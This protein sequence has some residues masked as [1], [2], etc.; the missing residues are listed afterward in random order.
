M[1]NNNLVKKHIINNIKKSELFDYPFAHKFIE[2]IF[3]IE[4]YKL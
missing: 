4:I 1:I 3:P 2:N